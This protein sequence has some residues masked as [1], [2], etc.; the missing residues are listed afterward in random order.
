MLHAMAKSYVPIMER[1]LRNVMAIVPKDSECLTNFLWEPLSNESF[2]LEIPS[3]SCTSLATLGSI[4]E[5][6]YNT[7]DDDDATFVP[8]VDMDGSASPT[9]SDKLHNTR[10]VTSAAADAYEFAELCPMQIET[11][12]TSVTSAGPSHDPSTSPT[13]HHMTR[14]S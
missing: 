1:W 10:Q 8:D 14:R 6:D 12:A 7:D 4:K 11:A 9:A 3:K 13:R 2:P 5:L